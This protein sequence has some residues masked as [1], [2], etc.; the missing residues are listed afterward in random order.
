MKLYHYD[1]LGLYIGQSE[2]DPN[3]MEP[4]NFLIPANATDMPPGEGENIFKSGAWNKQPDNRGITVWSL[5]DGSKSV[6]DY[7]GAIKVGF[8]NAAP[9]P[10]TKFDNGSWIPDTDAMANAIRSKR[11][12][13]LAETDYL[14]LPDAPVVDGV[15]E[16]RALLRDITMQSGFPVSVVW[17][18]LK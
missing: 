4:G 17:P 1:T 16:Y 5:T 3:P 15:K 10:F 13:L 2:A 14:M 11:D 7:I 8:T 6:V 9:P 18:V 12:G